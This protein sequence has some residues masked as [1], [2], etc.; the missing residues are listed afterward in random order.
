MVYLYQLLL[1][2]KG[3]AGDEARA[4][5]KVPFGGSVAVRTSAG[6][7][8]VSASQGSPIRLPLPCNELNAIPGRVAR[9]N[10]AVEIRQQS[11]VSRQAVGR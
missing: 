2:K 5:A 10:Y 3:T 8:V 4:G 7:V 9:Q 11:I 6:T 1:I